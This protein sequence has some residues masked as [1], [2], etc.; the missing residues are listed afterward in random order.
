MGKKARF[1]EGNKKITYHGG[2]LLFVNNLFQHS[3][4]YGGNNFLIDR[5]EGREGEQKSCHKRMLLL[6]EVTLVKT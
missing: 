6:S 1:G 2:Y 5:G 3:M 4:G